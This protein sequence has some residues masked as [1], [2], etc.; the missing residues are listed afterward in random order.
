M[1]SEPIGSDS[2]LKSTQGVI[3]E[4]SVASDD[5]PARF[6]RLRSE[7]IE[8]WQSCYVPLLH[9]TYFFLLFKGDPSDAIYMEVELRRL[10][11]LKDKLSKATRNADDDHSISLATRYFC[12]PHLFSV[13]SLVI[14]CH[15]ITFCIICLTSMRA[16][17][18]EREMLCK[19]MLKML[20]EKERLD[21]Y[22]QW[23]IELKSK[24]RKV[25]LVRRLWADTTDISHIQD[26]AD[27]VARLVGIGQAPKEMFGLSFSPA[28]VPRRS[29]SWKHRR[30]SFA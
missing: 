21:L 30:L 7:I 11:Y 4:E 8:L 23:G 15:A 10:K 22:R 12:S 2:N 27:L 16:I 25:Q 19:L 18:S 5:W 6:E 17:N 14:S 1:H 13:S 28:Q 3:G 20:S 26:S 9:R 29:Q 24:R